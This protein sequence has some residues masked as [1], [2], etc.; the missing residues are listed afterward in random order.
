MDEG[1][2]EEY[3]CPEDRSNVVLHDGSG[4]GRMNKG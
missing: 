2:E 1:D 4:K 3:Y